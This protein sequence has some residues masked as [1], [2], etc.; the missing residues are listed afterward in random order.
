MMSA[1]AGGGGTLGRPSACGPHPARPAP[2]GCC[3]EITRV[4]TAYPAR[5]RT[6]LDDLTDED[7]TQIQQAVAVV[8]SRQ[9]VTLGMPRVAAS[10]LDPRPERPSV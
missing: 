4:R 9:V 2:A 7:R 6:D 5:V 1:T 10:V 8:R 3:E